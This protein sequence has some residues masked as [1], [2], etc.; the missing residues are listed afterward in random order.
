MG[1]KMKQITTLNQV[2]AEEIYAKIKQNTLEILEERNQ[3]KELVE[4]Q[5]TNISGVISQK[6][7]YINEIREKLSSVPHQENGRGIYRRGD[8][9]TQRWDSSG[10]VQV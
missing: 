10:V 5:L 4:R 8:R 6:Q 2:R 7:K 1:L 9:D 3:E